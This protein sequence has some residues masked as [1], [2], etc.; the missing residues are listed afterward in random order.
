MEMQPAAVM[1]TACSMHTQAWESV[2]ALGRVLIVDLE[3]ELKASDLVCSSAHNLLYINT[4]ELFGEYWDQGSAV[5]A[6]ACSCKL[7][8]VRTSLNNLSDDEW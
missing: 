2:C 5:V 4:C 7:R 8:G 1:V 3:E 6:L